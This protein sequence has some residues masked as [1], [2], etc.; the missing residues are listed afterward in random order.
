[1]AGG[2]GGAPLHG[3]AVAA[4]AAAAAAAAGGDAAAG[5]SATGGAVLSMGASP[6]A[7]V[8]ESLLLAVEEVRLAI[9]RR[10]HSAQ[11]SAPLGAATDDAVSVDGAH[12]DA[13]AA[14]D[15]TTSE[16]SWNSLMATL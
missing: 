2:G 3:A 15:G 9:R 12:H 16:A 7:A 10:S 13:S 8:R 6:F 11:H 1:M 4:T 14:G 5:A